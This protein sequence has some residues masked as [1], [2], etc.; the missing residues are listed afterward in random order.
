MFALQYLKTFVSPAPAC[1]SHFGHGQ[2]AAKSYMMARAILIED[3]WTCALIASLERFADG[4]LSLEV[5][6][7]EDENVERTQKT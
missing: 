6:L 7:R 4:A 2:K 1:C 3:P 5:A